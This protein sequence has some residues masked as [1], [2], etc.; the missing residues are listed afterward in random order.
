MKQAIVMIP[1]G[2]LLLAAAFRVAVA[3]GPAGQAGAEQA[4]EGD[5]VRVFAGAR[6][7]PV[8]SAP[9]DDGVMVVVGGKI[10]AVG[11]REA[12]AIPAGAEVI[13]CRGKVI[14][15]GLVCTHSHI[16]SPSGGDMS[17]PVQP[18]A[19]V[20]DSVDVRAKSVARARAGGVT[21][22]NVMP[23]SGHLIS[24]QTLY[25]KLREGG[26]IE[27]LALRDGAGGL[28]G[29]LKMANGTNSI[30]GAPFPG[31]RGKS[32]ALVR[33][34]FLK[35]QDYQR[36]KKAAGGDPEKAPE[37]DL[38]ME[39]LVEVLEG[40]R[41]VHHHTHRADDILTVLRLREEFG[42]RVVLHHVSDAWKVADEI[43]ASGAGCSLIMLDSP[44]GKLEA[45][46][47]DLRNGAELEKRGVVT[48]IHTD[49]PVTDSRWMLRSAALAVRA[50][51]SPA[52]AIESVT[53][54]GARLLGLEG[55]VGSLEAGKDADFVVLTGEP[56]SVYTRVEET[57]VEGRKVFD[58]ERAEDRLLAEGGEGAG[59][60]V[61]QET[62]CFTK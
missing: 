6:L 59:D 34:S 12:V 5:V 31:T 45:R 53:L 58:L 38:A 3:G 52:R 4:A 41:V 27:D 18:E 24:G 56:L 21:L 54:A 35:A 50:G 30:R 47:F 9:L 25:L 36:K 26:R 48:A 10:V 32:A 49:D 14:M 42:F 57:W 62:C 29:G 43:A 55:R 13:D 2:L 37:R 51:M 23:G 19:R 16:G 60:D 1:A 11:T 7:H 33:Q 46:D 61:M 20:L 17:S 15:P 39:S 28:L 8:S 22:A 40:R 44:G